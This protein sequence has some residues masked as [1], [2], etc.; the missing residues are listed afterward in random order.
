MVVSLGFSWFIYLRWAFR[1]FPKMGPPRDQSTQ[2]WTERPPAS[3]QSNF[4]YGIPSVKK[5]GQKMV[6]SGI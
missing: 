1:P 6:P 4:K 2:Q 3:G 5:R